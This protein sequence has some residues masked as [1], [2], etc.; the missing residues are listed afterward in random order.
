MSKTHR[1]HSETGSSGHSSKP[2]NSKPENNASSPPQHPSGS[3]SSHAY[4]ADAIDG[5]GD[6]IKGTSERLHGVSTNIG[7]VNVGPQSMGLLGSTFTSQAQDAVHRAQDAT[8]QVGKGMD[9][10]HALTK[11]TAQTYRDTENSNRQ[12]FEKIKPAAKTQ[13]TRRSTPSSSTSTSNTSGTSTGSNIAARL[14]P[15]P[16]S[17]G[18]HHQLSQAE[19]AMQDRR[20]VSLEPLDPGNHANP[21]YIA[22]LDD[23]TLGVYKPIQGEDASLRQG[24]PGGLAHR[25]V[26][27]SRVDEAFGFHRVPTTTMMDGDHGPGSV[28]QFVNSTA[29]KAHHEYPRLQQEQMAVLDYV[30][31]NTDRHTGNYRTDRNGNIVAIDHGYSFPESPDPRFG[32]RSDFVDKNL[33]T[34]LSNEVMTAVRAVDPDQLRNTLRATGLGE[35]AIDGTI[36][37]LTEIQ[38]RGMITGE[39]WPGVINGAFA[40]PATE[41]MSNPIRSTT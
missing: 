17:P 15:T 31:G 2:E 34:P 21:A 32:I 30:T 37:R 25:E 6:R 41:S 27:A 8:S 16:P 19:R 13:S 14:Q 5:V 18:G 40:P 35:A 22:S 33:H 24:I 36:A 9:N 7:N 4:D 1:P 11:Q 38:T 12:S 29:S 39:A 28:Q 23:G 3:E 20:I 10:A 26:A